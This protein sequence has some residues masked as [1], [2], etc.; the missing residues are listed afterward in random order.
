MAS[1]MRSQSLLLAFFSLTDDKCRHAMIRRR[2]FL[3]L[4][5]VIP[6]LV[7]SC[8]Q[9]SSLQ[10][11]AN[12]ASSQEA[13][14]IE[15]I[16][17]KVAFENDGNFNRV[18]ISR[19]RVQTDAGVKAW[20]ILSFPFQSATQIIEIDYV[21]VHKVDG[22]TIVTPPDNIQDLDA[23]ITRSAPFYSDLREKHVAV[24]GLGKGDI[25]EYEAHWNPIKALVPGQFWYQ[26]NFQR[27][28]IVL[29]ER[30]EI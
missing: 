29:S 28:A 6:A 19:V 14:V 13:A 23:E 26:Y 2:W 9:T 30:L 22:S 20:G 27:E 5:V 21:R 25:L 12:D 10:S 16:A 11:L 3:P 24:K 17:T 1:N 4:T 7:G 15:S 8:A 18:K